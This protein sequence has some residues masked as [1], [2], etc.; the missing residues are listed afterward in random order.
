MNSA[1][2]LDFVLKNNLNKKQDFFIEGTTNWNSSGFISNFSDY[3]ANSSGIIS[4]ILIWLNRL[5][6]SNYPE[7]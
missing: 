2:E 5:F 1:E 6:L 4:F 3:L 7:N